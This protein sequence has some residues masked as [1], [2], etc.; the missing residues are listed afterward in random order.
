MRESPLYGPGDEQDRRELR[1]MIRKRDESPEGR[2]MKRIIT[3]EE[4]AQRV[5]LG[6]SLEGYATID[7]VMNRAR[8][9]E[10]K[11]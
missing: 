6:L 11:K 5:E 9:A 8:Y 7:S 3:A 10:R 1:E 4:W 2:K